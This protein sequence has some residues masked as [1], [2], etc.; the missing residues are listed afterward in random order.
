MRI[1]ITGSSGKIGSVFTALC[2]REGHQVVGYDKADGDDILDSAALKKALEGCDGVAHLAMAMG[3]QYTPEE[4]YASGTL[5]TWN[6]LQA[7]E[8]HGVRRIVSYSSV[9]AMGIFMGEDTPDFLPIDESQ[10]VYLLSYLASHDLYSVIWIYMLKS[11]SNLVD[12]I[13]FV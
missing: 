7:A 8:S 4:V 3:G 9:N 10:P 1:F 6:V 13:T 11:N 5:G 12:I 2:R